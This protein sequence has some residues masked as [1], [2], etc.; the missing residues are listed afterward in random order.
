VRDLGTWI[1]INLLR[2]VVRTLLALSRTLDRLSQ[3]LF[4]RCIP[5]IRS[6]GRGKSS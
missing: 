2:L 1:I 6:L 5:I 4:R 3:S